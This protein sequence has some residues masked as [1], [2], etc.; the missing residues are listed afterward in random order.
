MFDEVA[1]IEQFTLPNPL[2]QLLKV[3]VRFLILRTQ[4]IIWV[5]DTSNSTFIVSETY[6]MLPTS[7]PAR[8]IQNFMPRRAWMVCFGDTLRYLRHAGEVSVVI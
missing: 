6:A 3:L 1:E 4:L 7:T 5:R 2:S 8:L